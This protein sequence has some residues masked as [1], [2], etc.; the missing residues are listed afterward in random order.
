MGEI[1]CFPTLSSLKFTTSVKRRK[2]EKV[3]MNRKDI[4]N[5]SAKWRQN[6]DEKRVNDLAEE[7]KE[8][9]CT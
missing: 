2:R 4:G 8:H 9:L 1:C 5:S 7:E 6:S 3:S